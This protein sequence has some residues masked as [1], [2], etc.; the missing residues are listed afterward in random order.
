MELVRIAAV[1]RWRAADSATA[2]MYRYHEQDD[3]SHALGDVLPLASAHDSQRTR[4][5]EGRRTRT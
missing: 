5:R 1:E 4:R 2:C 3:V